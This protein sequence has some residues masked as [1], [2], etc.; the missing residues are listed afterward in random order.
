MGKNEDRSRLEKTVVTMAD[1][2]RR[3]MYITPGKILARRRW[4]RSTIG[5]IGRK[6][7]LPGGMARILLSAMASC[8]GKNSGGNGRW[9]PGGV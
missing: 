3:E 8:E 4:I 5:R 9:V 1:G 6:A 2:G 7:G